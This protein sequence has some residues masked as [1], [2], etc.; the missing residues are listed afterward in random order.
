MKLK[1][2]VITSLLALTT[3]TGTLKAD[4]ATAYKVQPGDTF[5]KIGTKYGVAVNY[6]KQYNNRTS[7]LLY[8]GET[9]QIPSSVTAAEKDLLARLVEAEAKGEPYAGKVAV[10]TVVLNRV[11]HDQFPNSIN[12][13]IY[14]KDQFTPVKNGEI[15][16]PASAE[17]KRAVNEALAFRGQGK[18]SIYFYNPQK[19]SNQWLRTKQV[20]VVIGNH[21]FAK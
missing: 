15:N 14:Q 2:L 13:V 12:G 10:A 6:L 8:I 11:S 19:T 3:F 20:T 21:V 7:D 17:S 4:A 1:T 18:G 5:W 16:K 9:I